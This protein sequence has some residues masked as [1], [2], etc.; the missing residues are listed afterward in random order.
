MKLE[1]IQLGCGNIKIKIKTVKKSI[2]FLF[3]VKIL[4]KP[5]LDTSKPSSIWELEEN[6][7]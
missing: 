3:G 4:K 5:R 6:I 2:K 7:L 1:K